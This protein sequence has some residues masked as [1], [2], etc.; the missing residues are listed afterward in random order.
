MSN[1]KLKSFA[2]LLALSQISASNE[3]YLDFN[4]KPFAQPDLLY[5]NGG[6][7]KYRKPTKNYLYFFNRLIKRRKRNKMAAKSRRINR[8]NQ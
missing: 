2:A 3:D 5:K 7:G 6:K 4:S 8:K 1:G